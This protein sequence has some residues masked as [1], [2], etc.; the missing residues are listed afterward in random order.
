[1]TRT[2]F[3]G[4]LLTVSLTTFIACGNSGDKK[5]KQKLLQQLMPLK[6]MKAA[7]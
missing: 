7:V 2:L 4:L 6:K 1:M 3:S 5:T